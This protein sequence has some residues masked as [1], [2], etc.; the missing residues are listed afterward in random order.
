MTQAA[1][2]IVNPAWAPQWSPSRSDGVTPTAA[3][4]VR[5]ASVPQWSPS[6]SD[7]VTHTNQ[8]E[9]AIGPEAAMEPVQIG[10]GDDD[11]YEIRT[12]LGDAAM[13]PVQIGRGDPP[14]R[15]GD[16]RTHC[17]RNGARPDRTG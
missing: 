2:S 6:R 15:C 10:R 11:L 1:N 17:G 4:R 16:H 9:R 3:G 7:G 5:K 8:P 12:P 14:G 13:E